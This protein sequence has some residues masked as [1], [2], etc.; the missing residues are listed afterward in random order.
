MR[1]LG[2]LHEII[3]KPTKQIRTSVYRSYVQPILECAPAVWDPHTL[4]NIKKL[5]CVQRKSIS[6]ICN[7]Y[8][9]STYPSTPTPPSFNLEPLDMQAHL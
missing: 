8:N 4:A 5:D 6:C 2:C 9:T 7:A 1:T 3:G